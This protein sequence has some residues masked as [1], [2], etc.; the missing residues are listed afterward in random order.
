MTY[1]TIYKQADLTLTGTMRKAQLAATA[2]KTS[3][4]PNGLH[5]ADSPAPG[6]TLD[7]KRRASTMSTLS[8]LLH[9]TEDVRQ[10][11]KCHI[12]FSPKWWPVAETE[13]DEEKVLCHKCHWKIAAQNGH[14]NEEDLAGAIRDKLSRLDKRQEQSGLRHGDSRVSVA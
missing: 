6:A 11:D 14:K 1:I 10:C 7:L 13:L 2:T 9:P 8:H 3:R 12:K 4:R 5:H